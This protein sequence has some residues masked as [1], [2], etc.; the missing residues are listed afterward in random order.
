V[1]DAAMRGHR[2][3]ELEGSAAGGAGG[4]Q[5]PQ[6]LDVVRLEQRE[7]FITADGSAIRE[8]AGIPAGNARNQSLAEATV[9][10]G[11]ETA[12]HFH[13]RAEEIYTF[14]AGAGRLRLGSDE[15]AVRAGDTVVISP[16]VPHKLWNPGPD[17]LVLLCCCAPPY[18][19]EDT[20]LL[21]EVHAR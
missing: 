20:V 15:T 19:H 13:R 6:P 11:G 9:P 1:I 2:E 16:G 5:A 3:V 7:S 8:L 14:T 17:P 4:G 10:P 12:E 18:S 21:E